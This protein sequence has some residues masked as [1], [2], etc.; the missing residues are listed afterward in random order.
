MTNDRCPTCGGRGES[1]RNPYPTV[2]V[3]VYDPERGVVLVERGNEPYGHALPGGFVDYGERVED[4]AVR[5]V[6]EE[7]GLRVRLV[8]LLGVWSDPARDPRQ[9]NMSVVFVGFALDGREPVGGDDAARAAWHSLDALP[10]DLCFDHGDILAEFRH[11]LARYA[12]GGTS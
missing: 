7:T 11:R 5:E 3:I 8:D 2:D 10:D 4:A 6:R 12:V 1:R 9:H